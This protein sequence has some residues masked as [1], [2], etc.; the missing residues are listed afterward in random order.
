MLQMIKSCSAFETMNEKSV[1]FQESYAV[2]NPRYM[3]TISQMK[4]P[5]A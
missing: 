5:L 2:K 3:S 1:T 4:F